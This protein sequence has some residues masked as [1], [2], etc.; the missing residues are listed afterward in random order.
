MRKLTRLYMSSGKRVVF[1][2]STLI[3]AVL[4]PHSIPAQAL[5]WAWEVAKVIIS[6]A[7]LLELQ[8]VLGRSR[9]DRY[10]DPT[11]RQVFFDNYRAMTLLVPVVTDVQ[12]CRD[13]KDDKFLSLAVA[14]GASLIVSSDDDLLTLGRYEGI[15]ILRPKAFVELCE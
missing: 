3:S 7:T 11:E 2:T 12:A 4:K 6:D 9:F 5:S 1:D 13:P 14:G 8:T 15:R 10:S